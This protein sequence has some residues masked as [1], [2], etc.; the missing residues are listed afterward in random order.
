MKIDQAITAVGNAADSCAQVDLDA[1]ETS[2]LRSSVAKF[3]TTLSRL[4]AQFARMTHAADR[5]GAHIG[6][7]ARDT[8]EWVGKETAT[9]TR[10]NRTAAELGEAHGKVRLAR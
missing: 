9:S 1:V 3:R 10:K 6:T 5:A 2:E 8:A 7:G 4:E